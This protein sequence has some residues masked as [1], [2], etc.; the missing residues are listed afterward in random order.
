MGAPA[1]GTFGNFLINEL[2]GPAYFNFDLGVT[3]RI[4]ITERVRFEFK[5]TFI[6]VL[7]HFNFAYGT[8]NFD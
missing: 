7:N 1:P 5:S 3:K 6:N 8:L 2:R 4:P